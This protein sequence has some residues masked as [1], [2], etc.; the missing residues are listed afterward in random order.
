MYYEYKTTHEDENITY[1]ESSQA[2]LD[3]V[4]TATKVEI[5]HHYSNGAIKI[6]PVKFLIRM[7]QNP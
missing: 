2:V 6:T 3:A 4:V 5:I 1:S 7:P